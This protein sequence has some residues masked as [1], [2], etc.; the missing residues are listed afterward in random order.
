LNFNYFYKKL[1]KY[2]IIKTNEKHF[3]GIMNGMKAKNKK[4]NLKI[5]AAVKF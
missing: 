5:I 1:I 3:K 4:K 2:K